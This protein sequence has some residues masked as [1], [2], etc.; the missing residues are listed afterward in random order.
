MAHPSGSHRVAA[1]GIL[2]GF[3]EVVTMARGPVPR[4]GQAMEE[5]GR[6]PEGAIAL[7]QGKV[8][9]VGPA[10]ELPR[11]VRLRR[12]GMIRTFPGGV[13]LPG[14]VDAHTH[15]LFAGSRE[16][17]LLPKVRGVSYREIAAGGGGLY[18]TVRE[19][20]AASR[21]RLLREAGERLARMVA[22]GTTTLEVKSGYGLTWTAERRLLTLVPQLARTTGVTLVATF[23]GAHAF[24]PPGEVTREAY[25]RDLLRHQIPAVAREG[26]ARFVDVFCDEGFFTA[27]E[28]LRILRAA[29]KEGLGAKI[30]ADE[31]TVSGGA[32]VAAEV[33]AVSADHLVMTPPSHRKGLARAGVV[34]VILPMTPLS[35]MAPGRSP[36]RELVDEGVAVALGSDLSPNS[37]VE[38]MPQ[39][40]AHAVHAARLT[41]AEALT[42]ATVNAAHAIG[43]GD[44]A[45]QIAPGRRADLVVFPLPS[46]EH[47]PYRWGTTP[48]SAVF[49]GGVE[50]GAGAE[51]RL[52]GRSMG[53]SRGIPK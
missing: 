10:R 21:A 52:S 18:R 37:W 13:A 22:W 36:G 2:T 1:D 31:F 23:L 26:R 19:T 48:P 43:E 29:R 17:E 7:S 33:G 28:S 51:G 38:A 45:G 12:G 32:R 41:P 20:R 35:S 49:V 11:V 42:A 44:R 6:I 50:W 47:I 46:A 40:I 34:G 39:V 27:R 5:M 8:A 53:I 24:P 14:F 4:R 25:L 16:G 15:L 30:H 9:W 3:S